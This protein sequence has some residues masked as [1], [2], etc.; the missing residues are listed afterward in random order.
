MPGALQD[1]EALL[2]MLAV[3]PAFLLAYYKA[4]RGA[5]VA[6]AAAMAVVSVTY[7]VTQILVRPMPELML[8][9]LVILIAISLG[10]GALAERLHRDAGHESAGGFTDPATGLPNRAHADLHLESEFKS[11]A[12]RS[13]AV[14]LFDVDNFK[15]FNSRHGAIAGDEVLR[16]VAE[17]LKKMTRRMNL[18]ARYAE[19]E[20]L[21]VLSGADE[22]G[23]IA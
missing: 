21:A 1:Y 18:S 13:F 17:V 7:A 2:W 15:G 8:P 9:V 3:V 11:S 14:V 19:D 16:M 12:G 10:V 20:F 23:A 6:L 22:E 4:W 5:A